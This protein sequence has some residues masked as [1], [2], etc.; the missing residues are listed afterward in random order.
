MTKG[1][2]REKKITKRAM[3]AAWGDSDSGGESEEDEALMCV[4]A[5]IRGTDLMQTS[6]GK[7]GHMCLMAG[8]SSS[9]EEHVTISE[10]QEQM[11]YCDRDE[12]LEFI[13]FA[14]EQNIK[15]NAAYKANK[16]KLREVT[17]RLDLSECRSSELELI[18][19]ELKE[20]ISGLE[21]SLDQKNIELELLKPQSDFTNENFYINNERGLLNLRRV[22]LRV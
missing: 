12:L 13:E 20:K 19:T 16:K 6:S 8:S 1:G 18:C 11:R 22:K 21:I 9:D 4:T 2:Q 17:R 14:I 3:L 7:K 5:L 15:G 10:M